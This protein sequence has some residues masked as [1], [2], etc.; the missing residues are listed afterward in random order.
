MA[1]TYGGATLPYARAT[2]HPLERALKEVAYPGVDGLDWMNLG[3]RGRMI[4]IRGFSP[5]GSTSQATLDALN[6]GDAAT[7]SVH[8]KSFSNVLCLG[9]TYRAHTDLNGI[10]FYYTGQ[11]RQMEE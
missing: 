1:V 8:G 10:G 5:A 7:L 4:V 6:D 3:A 9:F 11:F 2:T